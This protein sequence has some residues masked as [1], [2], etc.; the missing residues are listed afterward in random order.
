MVINEKILQKRKQDTV[1]IRLH[2]GTGISSYNE[3]FVGLHSKGYSL[4]TFFYP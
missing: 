4:F 3:L 1:I 2:W